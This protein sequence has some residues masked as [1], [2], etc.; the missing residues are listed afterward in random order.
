MMD[1]PHP[2]HSWH[3]VDP[4]L[5]KDTYRDMLTISRKS[6]ATD[7]VREDGQ[8][9]AFGIGE[10]DRMDPCLY[11]SLISR[12]LS[13]LAVYDIGVPSNR[14]FFPSDSRLG[15]SFNTW[16]N[17]AF[18]QSDMAQCS[19][20]VT[21]HPNLTVHPFPFL[22]SGHQSNCTQLPPTSFAPATITLRKRRRPYTKH[23]IN[24]LEREYINT[25]YVSKTRRWELS[26]RISLSE[27]Q[28]KIWFQNRRIKEKKSQR[29]TQF[30][31]QTAGNVNF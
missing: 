11:S 14:H 28:I 10:N 15:D 4:R 25:A 26:Q 27:R 3:T 21:S 5:T 24:E 13:R 18:K 19:Q 29:R 8:R 20:G 6:C 30:I 12:D 7:D 23:Q 31:C 1:L 22:Q 2:V 9:L 16:N 17:T